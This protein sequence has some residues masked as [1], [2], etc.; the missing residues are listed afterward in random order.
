MAKTK[1]SI[2]KGQYH[3]YGNNA[4]PVNNGRC[5]GDCNAMVVIPARMKALG[6]QFPYKK[7]ESG[8]GVV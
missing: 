3:G 1:C 4:Q 5:C 7:K 8:N 6:I 2:C